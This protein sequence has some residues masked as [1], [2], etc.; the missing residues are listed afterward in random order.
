MKRMGLDKTDRA[1]ASACHWWVGRVEPPQQYGR[2]QDSAPGPPHTQLAQNI[3]S[4]TKG[5]LSYAKSEP[6][7]QP[8]AAAKVSLG[9]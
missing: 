5:D 4:N 8:A 3:L 1:L 9:S 7:A 6:G 2:N